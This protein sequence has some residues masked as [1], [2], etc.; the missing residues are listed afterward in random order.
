MS[1]AFNFFAASDCGETGAP[2]GDAPPPAARA[3]APAAGGPRAT[4]PLEVVAADLSAAAA[5]VGAW[6][7]VRVDGGGGGGGALALR[8]PALPPGGV[9][10]LTG[11]AGADVVRGVYEGGG[12][13]WECT[14]DVLRLVCGGGGGG[15]GAGVRGR[16]VLDL[17]AGAGLL[18]AACVRL[19]ARAVVA[20]DLNASVLAGLTAPT[21]GAALAD[22]A[23]ADAAPGGAGE[24]AGRAG[25]PPVLLLAGS[26]TALADSLTGGGGGSSSGDGGG[27]DGRGAGAPAA[28]GARPPFPPRSVDVVVS[29][30]TLYD[31][32]EYAPLLAVLRA[33]LAPGGRALF[34]TKRLYFGAGLGGGSD[35]FEAAARAAGFAV[36]RVATVQD[37]ASMTRDVLELT[38]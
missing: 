9:D 13:V 12:K 33:A 19:G 30:E 3:P 32:G 27:G 37:G 17:G 16:A 8:R 15:G 14:L 11:A 25:V 5:A 1:F 35:A 24:G 10:A 4:S 28:A 6:S 23:L 31:P 22:A 20:Q 38:A 26:W 36:A 7:V 29:A 21:L 34:G 18:A 2:P